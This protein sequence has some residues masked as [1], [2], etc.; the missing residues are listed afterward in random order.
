MDKVNK[1]EIVTD[2][3]N[4]IWADDIYSQYLLPKD[5]PKIHEDEGIRLTGQN[6]KAIAGLSVCFPRQ[7]KESYL[8]ITGVHQDVPDDIWISF[9]NKR[10]FRDKL[11]LERNPQESKEVQLE[12]LANGCLVIV[13]AFKSQ[14]KGNGEA[15]RVIEIHTGISPNELF[16]DV[17]DANKTKIVIAVRA[18]MKFFENKDALVVLGPKM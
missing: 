18:F 1:K 6:S 7:K 9:H 15:V 8:T 3:I 10:D 17:S 2:L 13:P 11:G 4:R 14:Q 12:G 16:G 5:D